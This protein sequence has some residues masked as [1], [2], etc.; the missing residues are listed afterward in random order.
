[1]SKSFYLNVFILFQIALIIYTIEANTI[2]EG[3]FLHSFNFKL[4][5]C[6]N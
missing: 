2:D 4:F 1:M 3:K 5:F 6:S